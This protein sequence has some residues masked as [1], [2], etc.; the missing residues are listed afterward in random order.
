M[1]LKDQ[2]FVEVLNKKLGEIFY[3]FIDRMEKEGAWGEL[4]KIYSKHDDKV[5]VAKVYKDP[6][7]NVNLK[8]Y[9]NDSKKL[10][11]LQHDNIVKAYETGYIDYEG[12]KFF[13]IIL[14][15]INGKAL[16]E[17][18]PEILWERPYFER[19]N[20]LSQALDTIDAF[21]TKL[22]IHNDLHLGNLMYSDNK[23]I[24]IDFGSSK[25]AISS[26]ETDYD[27]YAIKH[28]LIDFFLTQEEI[29]KIFRKIS[30]KSANFNEIKQLIL[31]ENPEE[32][33]DNT[34]ARCVEAI[35]GIFDFYFENFDKDTQK[36]RTYIESERRKGIMSEVQT[37]NIYKDIASEMGVIITGNWDPISHS[38][39]RN[40]EIFI[41]INDLLI[42]IIQH[43]F[44]ETMRME[45]SINN[46]IILE[47]E[48]IE[49]YLN[50]LRH[51]VFSLPH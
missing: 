13:F 48:D 6:I 19:I 1:S 38:K 12:E 10:K 9:T 29:Q 4:F 18:I 51:V 24:I 8:I 26:Q 22:E 50:K 30:I 47:P 43:E 7:D 11:K 20:L 37:L 33:I 28:E 15:Y 14:D 2:N 32:I 16:D 25:N 23:I 27:L 36:P 49:S 39:G 5:R 41:N 21:R 46:K 44:G 35:V 45:F 3:V 40:H 34:K 42:K 31:E 17:I